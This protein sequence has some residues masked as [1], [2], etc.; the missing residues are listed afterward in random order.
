MS[1]AGGQQTAHNIAL[2][3]GVT[4][5]VRGRHIFNGKLTVLERSHARWVWPLTW[6]GAQRPLLG[7]SK[8][9]LIFVGD[10]ADLF[11]EDRPTWVIDRAV[12]TIAMSNHI[13]LLL[14]KRVPRMVDYFAASPPR[15]QSKL[16]L[17]F[18]AERQQEFDLRW[19]RIRSL[20]ERGWL[21]FV[22]IA[23]MIGPVRL[24]HDFMGRW[25]IVSGEE[26]PDA[27]IRI[28]N[29][30]WARA[31]RDQ[32]HAAGIPFFMKQMTGT[33][34]IPSDLLVRQFPREPT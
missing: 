11:H 29:P 19:S 25:V 21:V 13:G 14:T 4:D 26:G 15:W 1:L 30:N 34:P 5:Q 16:W 27:L 6:P 8:P 7:Q 18:S 3:L 28:M 17:G 22:S 9:S 32:C 31:V 23:P 2:Y 10:M 33:I 12:A 20:A 24:P